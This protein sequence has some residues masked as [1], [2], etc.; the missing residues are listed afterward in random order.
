[1]DRLTPEQRHIAMSHI[2]NKNTSIEVQL[3]KAL[4][5]EGIRYRK[6]YKILPGCPDIAITKYKIAIFCDGE[7]W[8]G[9]N[10]ENKK[11]SIKTNR[12][13]WLPKIDRNIA[14]DNKIEREL[15][16]MGWVILR[17]WGNEIKENLEDC[18][19]EVKETIYEIKNGIYDTEYNY[20]ADSLVAENEQDY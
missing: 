13:Y 20:S 9:K 10:W 5:K 17:Y 7:F 3:R 1:M 18:V 19:N 4:W 6:N 11:E 16:N 2:R 15:E 8:H 14:R 12:D